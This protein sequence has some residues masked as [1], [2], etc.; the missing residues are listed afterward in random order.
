MSV[1]VYFDDGAFP[2]IPLEF[3]IV[4]AVSTFLDCK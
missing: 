3:H 1:I 2:K 4:N